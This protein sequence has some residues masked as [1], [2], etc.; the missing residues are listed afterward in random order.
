VFAIAITLLILPLTDAEIDGDRIGDSLIA[1]LPNMFTFA[2][3]FTIIGRYWILHHNV[4]DRLGRA[5]GT[6]LVLNLVY[7]ACIVF[8]PFP[9]SVLGEHGPETASV[10]LYGLNLVAIGV[11]SFALWWYASRHRALLRSS[12]SAREARV[13]LA[14]TAAPTLGM[15]PSVP[16]AFVSPQWA[17][18]SWLLVIPTSWLGDRLFPEREPGD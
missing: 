17:A 13:R 7:L 4:I 3:S 6:L 10:L 18:L 5:D 12:V 15:I 9:T 2:L 8:L 1:L 11:T 14:R 16:L